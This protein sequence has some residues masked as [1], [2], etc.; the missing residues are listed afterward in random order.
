MANEQNDH[1]RIAGRN[2]VLEALGRDDARIEKVLLQQGLDSS[3]VSD[4]RKAASQTGVQVQYVPE[5]RLRKEA[6][7]ANHQGVVAIAAP[8]RYQEVNDMLAHIAPTREDV[9]ARRPVL[10]LLDRITDPYNY[11]AVLR[12]AVAMGVS[13]VIVPQRHMAPL[14]ATTIKASAGTAGRVP[15]ARTSSLIELIQQL[16]ERAY[17]IAGAASEGEQS[18]WEMDWDRP[19]AL[20]VGSEGKG[21][22]RQ[23]LEACDFQVSIPMRGPA[24]S[25]NVSVAAGILMAAAARPRL[26]GKRGLATNQ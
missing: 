11:G 25:L 19:I 16:K 23:V 2:P 26:E 17:W 9:K 6:D 14:S 18:I 13:G 1:S 22:R 4:I 3:V 12:S 20:V 21:I 7:G 24:E 15:I 8:I 5:E 10:L